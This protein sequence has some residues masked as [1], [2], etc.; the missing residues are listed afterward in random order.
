M[1]GNARERVTSS[2]TALIVCDMPEFHEEIEHGLVQIGYKAVTADSN[3]VDF[4]Q[5]LKKTKPAVLVVSLSEPD[6]SALAN[7]R[8]YSDTLKYSILWYGDAS[9]ETEEGARAIGATGILFHPSTTEQLKT[10]IG[11]S[12]AQAAQNWDFQEQI[13]K[14]SDDLETRK[15]VDR[16]RGIVMQ[17][18][19]LSEEEAYHLLRRESRRQR[20]PMK[21]ISQAVIMAQGFLASGRNL[22]PTE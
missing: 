2:P 14:L 6:P 10:V 17:Q 21:E 16:A 22:P 7:L 4:E 8:Q 18:M 19:N 12:A 11:F 3:A 13:A 5:I 15:L 20:K 1:P 9:E